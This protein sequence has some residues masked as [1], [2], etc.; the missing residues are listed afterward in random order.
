MIP[1]NLGFLDLSWMEMYKVRARSQSLTVNI[2]LPLELIPTLL[3]HFEF[4]LADPKMEFKER[5]W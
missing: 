5:C 4:E 3:A 1:S 2:Y